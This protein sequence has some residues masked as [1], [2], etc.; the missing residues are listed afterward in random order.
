MKSFYHGYY[1]YYAGKNSKEEHITYFY[2]LWKKWSLEEL[3]KY[4]LT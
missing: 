3:G 2:E 1:Y 4:N